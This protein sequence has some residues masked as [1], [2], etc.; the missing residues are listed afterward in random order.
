MPIY[1]YRCTGCSHEMEAIQK[2]SDQ[3]LVACPA[4]KQEQ[5]RKKISRV[6]FRLK[7]SGWYETDFKSGQQKNVATGDEAAAKD[8]PDAEGSKPESA[9]EKKSDQNGKGDQAASSAAKSS[10]ESSS[11]GA[12]S[13]A[14]SSE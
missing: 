6:A 12:A 2:I 9:T 5:L 11:G 10:G 1:E 4:C 14:A 13:K 8:K 7:G 3:P